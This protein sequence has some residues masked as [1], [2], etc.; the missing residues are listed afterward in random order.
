MGGQPLALFDRRYILMACPTSIVGMLK[1]STWTTKPA[2]T[3]W[4]RFRSCGTGG[5]GSVRENL[6]PLPALVDVHRSDHV[7]IGTMV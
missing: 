3:S 1:E 2:T 4:E 5:G 6:G 7:G